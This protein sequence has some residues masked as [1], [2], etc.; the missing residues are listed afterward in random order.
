M[1]GSMIASIALSV[2]ALAFV[3]ACI[4]LCYKPLRIADLNLRFSLRTLAIL[5]VVGP[6]LL[7]A[8]WTNRQ[9]LLNVFAAPFC[10][11]CPSRRSPHIC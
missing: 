11:I 1:G 2:A 7:A 9:S 4:G 8:A 10:R 6:P 3:G 5:T